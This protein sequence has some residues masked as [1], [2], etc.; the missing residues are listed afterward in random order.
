MYYYK[1]YKFIQTLETA[2]PNGDVAK[3]HSLR[4]VYSKYYTKIPFLYSVRCTKLVYHN[5]PIN[6]AIFNETKPNTF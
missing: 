6:S 3:M 2:K 4:F 5:F 1:M